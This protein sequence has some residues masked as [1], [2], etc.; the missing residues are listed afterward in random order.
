LLSGPGFR[1]NQ[2]DMAND[3]KKRHENEF[4]TTRQ[5]KMERPSRI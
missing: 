1:C 2:E 3:Q 5:L 4:E